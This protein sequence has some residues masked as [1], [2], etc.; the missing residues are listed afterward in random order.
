MNAVTK[1]KSNILNK[2]SHNIAIA[3]S[4]KFVKK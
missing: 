4:V 3:S 1:E 2:I